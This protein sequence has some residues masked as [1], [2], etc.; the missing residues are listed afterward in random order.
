[1]LPV[2]NQITVLQFGW[3]NVRAEIKFN[4]AIYILYGIIEYPAR[5]IVGI[6]VAKTIGCRVIK[7]QVG[8]RLN[9]VA[10]DGSRE[11]KDRKNTGNNRAPTDIK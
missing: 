6:K 3:L 1:M 2:Y 9:C 8:Y 5:R 4:P 7:Q 11:S 10:V